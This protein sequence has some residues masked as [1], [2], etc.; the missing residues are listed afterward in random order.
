MKEQNNIKCKHFQCVSGM[1]Y[2]LPEEACVFCEY[3]T[4]IL[5]NREA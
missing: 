4:D 5:E 1:L 3:C 2:E